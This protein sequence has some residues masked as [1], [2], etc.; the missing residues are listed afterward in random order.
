MRRQNIR[1]GITNVQYVLLA[2]L[3][4]LAVVASIT[5]VGSRAS[6]KLNQTASDVSSP[7]ALANRFGS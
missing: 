2:A 3:I 1:R 5:L 4:S 7:S 6:T